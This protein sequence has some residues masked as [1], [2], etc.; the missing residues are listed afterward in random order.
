MSSWENKKLRTYFRI[1]VIFLCFEIFVASRSDFIFQDLVS[2]QSCMK[3]LE[4]CLVRIIVL[5]IF[6]K[7]VF[8]CWWSRSE[9]LLKF[10]SS[11]YLLSR[12]PFFYKSK[13]P[14]VTKRY[15]FISF[16]TFVD[17]RTPESTIIFSNDAFKFF[18]V[19]FASWR[20]LIKECCMYKVFEFFLFSKEWSCVL[21][22]IFNARSFQCFLCGKFTCAPDISDSHSSADR[23]HRK[24]SCKRFDKWSELVHHIFDWTASHSDWPF[25]HLPQEQ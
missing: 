21:S 16:F 19:V 4:F 14:T 22:S 23:H 20:F 10:C 12:I 17:K 6:I 7:C 15:S 3:F 5:H 24:I 25:E 13:L 2:S 1:V 11:M 18:C 9:D 8:I